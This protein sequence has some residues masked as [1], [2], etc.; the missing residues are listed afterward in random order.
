MFGSEVVPALLFLV[1]LFF[2]PESPRWLY[3]KGHVKQARQLLINNLGISRAEAAVKEIK[4]S[5]SAQDGRLRDFFI[6]NL[7]IVLIIGILVA[8]FQQFSGI[9]MIMNFATVIFQKSGS[10]LHLALGQ[11]MTIGI[12]NLIFTFLAIYL[13]DKVGRKLML[14]IGALGQA[15]CLSVSGYIFEMELF[16]GTWVLLPILLYVAFFASTVGPVVWVFVAEIFPNRLRGI[17]M[18]AVTFF[19]WTSNYLNIQLYPVMESKIGM[20]YSFWVYA[21]LNIIYMIFIL[22]YIPETK[23]RT[24]EQIEK[25]WNITSSIKDM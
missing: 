5:L 10:G 11:T 1:L 16:T 2:L 22:L 15:I 25:N 19:L 12:V 3:Q 4:E 23:G 13:V 17:G 18:A 7:R 20:G 6:G 14:W 24:L 9:N 21:G 8:V